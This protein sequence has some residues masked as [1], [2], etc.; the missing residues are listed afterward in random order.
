MLCNL[1]FK[2]NGGYPG[3][4]DLYPYDYYHGDP[5]YNGYPGRT[6]PKRSY[7]DKE[8]RALRE[9]RDGDKGKERDSGQ[10]KHKAFNDDFVSRTY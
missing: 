5:Y 3:Y 1:L 2:L 6:P 4:Y 10:E 9:G 7:H 8:G